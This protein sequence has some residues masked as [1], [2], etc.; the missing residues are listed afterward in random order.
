[1]KRHIAQLSSTVRSISVD[2]EGLLVS[3]SSD[4]ENDATYAVNYPR[5]STAKNLQDCKI[6]QRKGLLKLDRL[7]SEVD[8]VRYTDDCDV[9]DKAA[10][11]YD[12][13]SRRKKISVGRTAPH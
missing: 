7:G 2:D 12:I 6:V 3:V 13:I 5:Y 8:L 1:L 10:F 4:P 9:D 11:K